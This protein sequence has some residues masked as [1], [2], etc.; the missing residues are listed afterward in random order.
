MRKV[1]I[2]AVILL[3]VGGLNWGI[4]G[5]FD[6]NVIDYLFERMWIDRAI[7]FLIGVSGIYVIIVWKSL[8]KK[9]KTK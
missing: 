6:F 7:Y 8:F 5:S 3:I 1:D 9:P 4:Y 2:I